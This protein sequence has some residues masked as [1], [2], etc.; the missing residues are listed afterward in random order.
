[1]IVIGI[2]QSRGLF[3]EIILSWAQVELQ[4]DTGTGYVPLQLRLRRV[5]HLHPPCPAILRVHL[6]CCSGDNFQFREFQKIGLSFIS[7]FLKS[8]FFKWPLETG[9][10]NDVLQPVKFNHFCLCSIKGC[11]FTFCLVKA[12]QKMDF[13]SP[14]P[15]LLTT[16]CL[17]ISCCFVYW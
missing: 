7:F 2:L 12:T 5:P 13:S 6:Y 8:P 14:I 10:L 3:H 4:R 9:I 1:M 15:V 16:Q 17:K 11:S